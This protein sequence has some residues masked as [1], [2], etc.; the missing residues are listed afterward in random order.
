[1]TKSTSLPLRERRLAERVHDLEPDLRQLHEA[2]AVITC[3]LRDTSVDV[4]VCIGTKVIRFVIPE[5]YPDEVPIVYRVS[6]SRPGA[7][8][9]VRL[10]K[11]LWEQGVSLLE[12]FRALQA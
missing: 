4:D 6:R 1:V 10:K 7:L 2:G 8:E 11:Q 3:A 12:V 9:A 5:G